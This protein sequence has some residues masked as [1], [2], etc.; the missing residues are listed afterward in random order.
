MH[1]VKEYMGKH[2]LVEQKVKKSSV[3]VAKFRQ[4]MKTFKNWLPCDFASHMAVLR[5]WP[6]MSWYPAAYYTLI[7]GKQ[8]PYQVSIA[9]SVHAL[10]AEQKLL[11]SNGLSSTDRRV[12]SEAAKLM[13]GIE[14]TAIRSQQVNGVMHERMHFF[15]RHANHNVS[16]HMGFLPR[17]QKRGILKKVCFGGIALGE[18]GFRYQVQPFNSKV[19]IPQYCARHRDALSIINSAIPDTFEQYAALVKQVS[20][21]GLWFCRSAMVPR[22]IMAAKKKLV[23]S[24]NVMVQ[25]FVKVFPDENKYLLRMAQELGVT[26]VQ[27]VAKRIKYKKDLQF[28]TMDLCFAGQ[29]GEYSVEWMKANHKSLLRQ[30]KMG[31]IGEYQRHVVFICQSVEGSD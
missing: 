12:V 22:R 30:Q 24:K 8:E 26:T 25:D 3:S 2:K 7:E 6:Q 11:L 27:A 5:R 29:L 15:G 13:Y 20:Y 23:V 1:A 4:F 10:T 21:H 19:H 9:A 28:L 18:C 31:N 17:A 16:H 14:V